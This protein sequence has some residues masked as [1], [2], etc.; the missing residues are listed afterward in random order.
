MMDLKERQGW[1]IM[2]M[3]FSSKGLYRQYKQPLA[4]TFS[5]GPITSITL[6]NSIKKLIGECQKIG[7]NVMATIC[8]QGT[9][10]QAA[11]KLLIQER[12]AFCLEMG[13]DDNYFG[14]LINNKEVVPLFDTLHL[15]EGLRNNLLVKEA[16]FFF[17]REK[18]IA[19][20]LHIEQFYHLNLTDQTLRINNKLTDAHVIPE[21][22]NKMKVKLCTQVFSH[23]VGSM[24]KLISKREIKHPFQ[25]TLEAADTADLILLLDELFDSLNVSKAS[26]SAAKLMKRPVNKK[27]SHKVFWENA[28][29][30]LKSMKFYCPKNKRLVVIPSIKNLIRS[31][32]GFLYL[33]RRLLENKFKYFLTGSFNQDCLENFF[34]NIRDH[35][36]KLP[37]KMAPSNESRASTPG[38]TAVG[39]IKSLT[40]LDTE[41]WNKTY[42]NAYAAKKVLIR[43]EQLI[44]IAAESPHYLFAEKTFKFFY[45]CQVGKDGATLEHAIARDQLL[46][47]SSDIRSFTL[48][49]KCSLRIAGRTR[50][51]QALIATRA[52]TF[53]PKAKDIAETSDTLIDSSGTGPIA[54]IGVTPGQSRA[55]VKLYYHKYPQA[56]GM[57]MTQLMPKTPDVCRV[58]T[59]MY[60]NSLLAIVP[61]DIHQEIIDGLS[62]AVLSGNIKLYEMSDTEYKDIQ[63]YR[64]SPERI[65]YCAFIAGTAFTKQGATGVQITDWCKNRLGAMF[66]RASRAP[67]APP[68]EVSM[69]LPIL[70]EI[71]GNN[72]EVRSAL[73]RPIIRL[74]SEEES[75]AHTTIYTAVQSQIDLVTQNYMM[76]TLRMSLNFHD[77]CETQASTLHSVFSQGDEL[78]DQYRALEATVKREEEIKIHHYCV[79][80]PRPKWMEASAYPD[81]AFCAQRRL[82]STS[83]AREASEW[84]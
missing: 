35:E 56:M 18:K 43:D 76:S 54:D 34:G 50:L 17:N 29:E 73:L 33:S 21:K 57:G 14:F 82:L 61:N 84:D 40:F 25:L 8:D 39:T 65:M 11:I 70:A 10:N 66:A 77:M 26:K 13:V 45:Q 71:L 81:L 41:L 72:I 2:P 62:S 75:R 38:S 47:L 55:L 80:N 74:H 16:H 28:I 37:V 15:F 9:N 1:L 63:Y 42:P 6:K 4:F 79:V 58:I 51:C 64:A 27:S 60:V 67:I 5:K 22:I 19:K 3:Y 20:W 44:F 46:D 49:A 83:A 59:T 53:D 32:K 30:I 36:Y 31:L 68:A 69:E 48:A 52:D 24:M 23:S 12:K 7:L 78:T